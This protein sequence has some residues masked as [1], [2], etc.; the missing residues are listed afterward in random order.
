MRVAHALA[1]GVEVDD[2]DLWNFPEGLIGLPDLRRFAIVPIEGAEPFLLMCSAENPSFALVVVSPALLLPDYN[3]NLTAEDLSALGKIHP[4]E[5]RILVT[6]VLPRAGEALVL[7]LRG[8]ILL[9]PRSRRGVQRV[10]PDES[11]G[12]VPLPRTAKASCSS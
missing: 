12:S 8:P 11:H 5:T 2:A 4:D 10:S 3:L 7:N 9:S 1:Q 6:T